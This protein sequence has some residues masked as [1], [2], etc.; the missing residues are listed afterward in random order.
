M[1]DFR[2]LAINKR[3]K[4]YDDRTLEEW[5]TS[6]NCFIELYSMW[7][8]YDNM[9]FGELCMR[10]HRDEP[11]PEYFKAINVQKVTTKNPVPKNIHIVTYTNQYWEAINIGIWKKHIEDY[12]DS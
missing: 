8:F 2:Q 12:G 5:Y 3:K 4:I 10:F 11:L 1:G 7:N 6:L 9:E